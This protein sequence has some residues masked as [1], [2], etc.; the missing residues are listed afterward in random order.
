M[1]YHGRPDDIDIG[2]QMEFSLKVLSVMFDP[3]LNFASHIESVRNRASQNLY[4]LFKLKYLGFCDM[5]GSVEAWYLFLVEE[6][7]CVVDGHT[8]NIRCS[9]LRHLSNPF[10]I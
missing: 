5:P 2:K 9:V 7:E 4:F 3:Q 6:T 10:V 1:F 8:G